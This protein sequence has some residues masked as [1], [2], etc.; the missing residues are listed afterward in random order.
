MVRFEEVEAAQSLIN[1]D[2]SQ[3]I[4]KYKQFLTETSGALILSFI[5]PLTR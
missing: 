3:A 2:P 4:N 1:S 5:K